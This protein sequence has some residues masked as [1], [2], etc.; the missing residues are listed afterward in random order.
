MRSHTHFCACQWYRVGGPESLEARRISDLG[1]TG[2]LTPEEQLSACWRHKKRNGLF[3]N[4]YVTLLYILYQ[5]LKS[6]SQKV[7]NRPYEEVLHMFSVYCHI[8]IIVV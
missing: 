1:H 5:N 4:K 3:R 7:K 2:D 6:Q 8:V